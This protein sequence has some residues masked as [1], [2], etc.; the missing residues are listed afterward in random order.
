MQNRWYKVNAL[1]F[2]WYRHSHPRTSHLFLALH[3]PIINPSWP[4]P[5]ADKTSSPSKYIGLQG[6]Q[7]PREHFP[8][9][10]L[11]NILCKKDNCQFSRVL[12]T[13]WHF[14]KQNT[15]FHFPLVL[16]EMHKLSELDVYSI[17]WDQ[18]YALSLSSH[19]GQRSEQKLGTRWRRWVWRLP[20]SSRV[21][22]CWL[23]IIFQEP[24]S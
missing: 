20:Q 3:S 7:T 10:L 21:R 23:L 5:K 4:L 1:I 12:P 17:S 19:Q 9:V 18:S 2:A 14:A 8:R 15:S 6:R 22:K 24:V 11:N 16:M 13:L